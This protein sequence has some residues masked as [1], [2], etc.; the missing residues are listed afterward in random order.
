MNRTVK[1][2]VLIAALL[3][4]GVAL[5]IS[6]FCYGSLPTKL[7]E[8]VALVASGATLTGLVY[9]VIQVW[10]TKAIARAT[11]DAADKAVLEMRGNEYRYALL[12][13]ERLLSE[14]RAHMQNLMWKT[15]ALRLHDLVEQCHQLAFI[16][17]GVDD[18]WRSFAKAVHYWGSEFERGHDKRRLEYDR[19]EWQKLDEELSEKL[20]RESQPFARD[21]SEE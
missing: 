3:P 9:T 10:G 7:T 14:I 11:K 21:G 2:A 20:S 15:T 18:Q 8:R 13:A 6:V 1:T 16:R 5:G 12:R 4:L 19:D 17:P